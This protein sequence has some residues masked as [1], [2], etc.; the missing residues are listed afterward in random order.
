MLVGK[1]QILVTLEVEKHY[2]LPGNANMNVW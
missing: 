2:L 1:G